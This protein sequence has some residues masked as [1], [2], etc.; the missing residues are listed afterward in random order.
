MARTP[1][2]TEKDLRD[3]ADGQS[4]ESGLGYLEAVSALDVT[5]EEIY[6]VVQGTDEYEVVLTVGDEGIEGDCDCPYGLEGAFCKHCV[7]VGLTAL[8]QGRVLPAQRA[9]AA[10]KRDL[11][12]QWLETLSRDEIL[13]LLREQIGEDRDFRRSL[14]VR[15]ATAHGDPAALREGIL[16]LLDPSPHADR[17][18]FVG[19]REAFAYSNQASEAVTAIEALIG[20]DPA[21][22][23]MLAGQAVDLVSAVL[24]DADDS[25]AAI[26]MVVSELAAVHSAACHA[27]P[28]D[29]VELADWLA[30]R[31]LTQSFEV[32]EPGDYDDLL[33]DGGRRRFRR[34]IVAAW[35][36]NP[37][38]YQEK[39]L[40][41][42]L[43]RTTGD[44]DAIVTVLAAD[45]DGPG[46]KYHRI[47]TELHDAGR[48]DDAVAWAERGMAQATTADVRLVDFLADR[49]AAAGRHDQAVAVQWSWFAAHHSL[50]SYEKLRVA[51][52][53]A[54]FWPDTRER[55]LEVLR[56]DA[57]SA[58]KGPAWQ[59]KTVLIDALLSDGDLDGAWDA[60]Q[61]AITEDQLLRLAD[62]LRPTSPSKA[63]TAYLRLIEPLKKKTGDQNYQRI[64]RLLTSARDCHRALGS[65]DTFD[66]YLKALRASQKGKRNLMA[67]LDRHGL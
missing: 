40:M 39:H 57:R 47:V 25:S 29:P 27:A 7:A 3:A 30:D 5:A 51:A 62:L 6:A 53:P 26:S 36:R 66:E 37:S 67:V 11:L 50:A 43:V 19:Y 48:V 21:A 14:E 55:A 42:T 13:K 33:G 52:E 12:D 35:H 64:A 20:R 41:E 49:Y 65:T 59:P 17:Y 34:A 9:A 22:A 54:G 63:L 28:P 44:V 61:I 32:F 60:A 8:R 4:F 2:F 23:V 10:R 18:G 56:A 38:G 46:W 58:A 15:A 24:D 16:A 1:G 31:M 45:L